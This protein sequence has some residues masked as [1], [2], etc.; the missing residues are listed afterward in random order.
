MKRHDHRS[1]RGR[2]SF[3]TVAGVLDRDGISSKV[4]GRAWD[5]VITR[6]L[7]LSPWLMAWVCQPRRGREH[8]RDTP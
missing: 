6:P 4:Q 5:P 8:Q 2:D 7:L 1:L 3:L